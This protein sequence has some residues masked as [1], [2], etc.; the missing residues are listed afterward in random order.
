MFYCFSPSFELGYE[1]SNV[2]MGDFMKVS[3][4]LCVLHFRA[5]ECKEYTLC[6]QSQWVTQSYLLPSCNPSGPAGTYWTV[7]PLGWSP[8]WSMPSASL[9]SGTQPKSMPPG[10]REQ[11]GE[12]CTRGTGPSSW[13]CTGSA[14]PCE[15]GTPSEPWRKSEKE[16]KSVSDYGEF[17]FSSNFYRNLYVPLTI[18]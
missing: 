5:E 3:P 11:S 18:L 2:S 12:W 1:R 4:F 8:Q 6:W 14:E 13:S 16:H 17:N 15:T 9:G 10:T 7:D